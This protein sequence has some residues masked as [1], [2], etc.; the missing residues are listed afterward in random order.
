MNY[1]PKNLHK[2][3]VISCCGMFRMAVDLQLEHWNILLFPFIYATHK[4]KWLLDNYLKRG[5]C[6]PKNMLNVFQLYFLLHWHHV[7]GFANIHFFYTD[8]LFC[9]IAE[10]STFAYITDGDGSFKW[11]WD[12]FILLIS[13]KKSLNSCCWHSFS[14]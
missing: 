5:T 3:V 12:M 6:T 9:L 7:V 13:T 2:I 10:H 11:F 4:H 8:T 14:Q 1:F